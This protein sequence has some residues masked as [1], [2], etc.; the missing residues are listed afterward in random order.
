MTIGSK[1][2]NILIAREA[3]AQISESLPRPRQQVTE[4][5]RYQATAQEMPYKLNLNIYT[6]T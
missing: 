3:C 2:C 4:R 6:N 5:D 1:N